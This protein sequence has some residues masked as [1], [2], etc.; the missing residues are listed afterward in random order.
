MLGKSQGNQRALREEEGG[1]AAKT[2]MQGT[3]S[4]TTEGEAVAGAAEASPTGGGRAGAWGG[5]DREDGAS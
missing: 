2:I 4:A 5:E 3:G 1:G